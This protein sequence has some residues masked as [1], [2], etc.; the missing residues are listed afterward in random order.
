M[1]SVYYDLYYNNDKTMTLPISILKNS[2]NYNGT[3]IIP[4][5]TREFTFKLPKEHPPN[6]GYIWCL[7]AEIA[8][9]YGLSDWKDVDII[10]VKHKDESLMRIEGEMFDNSQSFSHLLVRL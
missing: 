9:L 8:N 5:S 7:F 4:D 1:L 10:L 2:E 6:Y 3:T